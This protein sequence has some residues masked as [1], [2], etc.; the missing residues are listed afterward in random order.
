MLLGFAN[1][2]NQAENQ[3]SV[4]II[5]NRYDVFGMDDWRVTPRLTLNLGVRWEGLPHA[6][7]QNNRL[8]NFYPRSGIRPTRRSSSRARTAILGTTGPRIHNVGGTK[9]SARRFRTCCSIMNGI[10]LAGRNEIPRGL[11]TNHWNN[12][13]PRLG[14]EYDL[15]GDGRTILRGGGGIYL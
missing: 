3:D 1:N 15:F 14:F 6:Y 12:I 13:G 8:S 7:D 9:L 4:N 2:F 11:A 5:N 10:G